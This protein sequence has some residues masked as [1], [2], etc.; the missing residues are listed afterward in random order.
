M[1]TTTPNFGWAVPTST[2]LVK[3]GA[4]A[5][6][7]LGDSIDASLVDLKGGTTGQVLSKASGTDMDFAWVS[8]AA[9]MT[10][11]MTTTGDTIYSSSGSTPARLGIGSTGQI[12]TVAGGVPTWATPAAGGGGL[13]FISRTSL[14]ASASPLSLNSIFTSTYDNYR[15]S[16]TITQSSTSTGLNLNMRSSGTDDSSGNYHFG[17]Y[18]R[19][20]AG[21][22]FSSQSSTGV[23]TFQNISYNEN[24]KEGAFV[25]DVMNPQVAQHTSIIGAG[26]LFAE[27][28]D[29]KGQLK[30]T[31]QYDGC[32]FSWSGN[33]TAVITVYGLAKS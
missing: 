15:I 23:T 6:E 17:R 10:N 21:A 3:D 33:L 31:T 19:D 32:T 30:T 22:S 16:V 20:W 28:Y 27:A 29:Y 1:A 18:G 4:V 11:P 25:F 12:L 9:G 2:D 7:T 24:N 26:T 5:I 14:S 13:V 8:D